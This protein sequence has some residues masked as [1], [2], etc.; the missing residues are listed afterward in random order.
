MFF[1]IGNV[2]SREKRT[3]TSRFTSK[4][5]LDNREL[6]PRLDHSIAPKYEVFRD[7]DAPVI[8]DVE[9]ERLMFK[10]KIIYTNITNTFKDINLSRAEEG[11]FDLNDLVAI[12]KLQNVIDMF[13]CAVPKHIKYVDYMCVVS[14]R[15]RK[16]MLGIAETVKKTFKIKRHTSDPI[17]KI[18]GET[19]SDWMA[20]D[21]GNIAMHIFSPAARER[22][23]LES[24]WTV[25]ASYD[26]EFNKPKEDM[27]QLFEK[28]TV[29]L[30]DLKSL[31]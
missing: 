15:N 27:V 7:I 13:V 28:H 2:V 1:R 21:L 26:R 4:G 23:D 30:H 17:P 12:L 5:I 8:F 16:H 9:E 20:M 29:Y 11:V 6:P 19:S 14:G 22:Y 3:F 10:R 25:G 24:L 31:N 18:E